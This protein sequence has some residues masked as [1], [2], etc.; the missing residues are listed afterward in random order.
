MFIL[1]PRLIDD[2]GLPSTPRVGISDFEV[3]KPISKGAYG[4]VFLARKVNTGDI[5][6]MKVV[7][8]DSMMAR[9][10]VDRFVDGSTILY[11]V[12][13]SLTASFYFNVLNRPK[14]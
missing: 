4:K 10:Q 12:F 7:S 5:F 13:P 1:P 2:S 3:V 11:V 6:A 14:Q 9:K 8:K